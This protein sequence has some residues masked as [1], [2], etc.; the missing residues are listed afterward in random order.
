MDFLI[1]SRP[2]QAVIIAPSIMFCFLLRVSTIYTTC[3]SPVSYHLYESWYIACPGTVHLV[4]IHCL[5]W[6]SFSMTRAA[7]P[8][9]F[10]NDPSLTAMAV[11]FLMD[12]AI[13]LSKMGSAW[14]EGISVESLCGLRVLL[15]LWYIP[16]NLTMLWLK[17]SIWVGLLSPGIWATIFLL[18]GMKLLCLIL[19]WCL[20]RGW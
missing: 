18:E 13:L 19:P 4:L 3:R 11:M 14:K 8:Q 9:L 15:V 12:E 10:F 7:V 5:L 6:C 2:S 16:V 1:D 17:F 20:S